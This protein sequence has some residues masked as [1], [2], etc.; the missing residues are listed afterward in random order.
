MDSQSV[1]MSLIPDPDLE[2]P[3]PRLERLLAPPG[4]GRAIL[5]GA[6]AI[7]GPVAVTLVGTATAGRGG[8]A[9]PALLYLLAVVGVAAVG[10]LWPGLAAAVL[11]FAGLDYYFT[12]PH[13]TFSVAKGEDLF[14]LAVFLV[15][16][17]AVSA[18]ISAALEQRA[19]AERGERQVRALY[20]LTALLLSGSDLDALL[21]DVVAALKVLF[22]AASCRVLVA[23]AG[24]EVPRAAVGSWPGPEIV[25][26]PLTADGQRMGTIEL[27]GP[28]MQQI[29]RSER[30]VLDAFAGQLALALERTRLGDE[31][32]QARV[33]AESSRIRAALFSSV[34][35]DLRTPLA[36]ITASASSLM[37]EGVPFTEEQRL[38]LLRTILEESQRL[39]RLV[40][41]LMD[42]SRLRA[43]A[44]RPSVEI[45]P[46]E[47]LLSSVL[48]RLRDRL[49][50]REIRVQI[51]EGIPPGAFDVVQMDQVLTN[52][53]ENAVRYSPPGTPI[54]IA[55][56]QWQH[57]LEVRVSDR[58]PGIP[59]EE[60][61]QV[62]EE[63]Y[64]R[65]VDGRKGGTG[66]GLAIAR[67]VVLAHGG[68][69]WVEETPGGGATIG[70]RL[71]LA[72]AP[73]PIEPPPPAQPAVPR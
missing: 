23:D 69:M 31:A 30:D 19:K 47:D 56:T 65:D 40:G 9:V 42:I 12:P 17:V 48:G 18:A 66:L 63:F 11:S 70:F 52:L 49:A 2:R 27:A 21:A 1:K 16:V 20:N 4:R 35:H 58:G 62:F 26:V 28:D 61:V 5:G 67:A 59:L 38:E 33:Q 15:V 6:L 14:A 41:N 37:E 50:G 54:T 22:G 34:T 10:H 46:F 57:D 24:G 71:P 45:V 53:V 68:T 13:H 64:R 55:A 3:P 72:S 29:G 36:S 60:R 8:T 44:L 51:R 32:A 73:E 43:G 25:R 39:N 7:A